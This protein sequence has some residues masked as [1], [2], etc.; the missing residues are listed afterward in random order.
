MCHEQ[1]L[2][3]GQNRK[4]MMKFTESQL[5]YVLSIYEISMENADV[6]SANIAKKLK[7]SKPSVSTMLTALMNEHLVVR[8]RYSKVYLTDEG[9]L[10]AKKLESNLQILAKR[11][12]QMGL[13]ISEETVYEMARAIAIAMPNENFEISDREV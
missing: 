6:S 2:S 4:A 13:G 3:S 8:E 1:I 5:K 7:I 9:Y 12:P 11:I 10:I